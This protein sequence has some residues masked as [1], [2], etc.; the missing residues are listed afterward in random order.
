MRR[1]QRSAKLKVSR[2]DAT[3]IGAWLVYGQGTN[4]SGAEASL[5]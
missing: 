4:G 3:D 5:E 1:K 2:P